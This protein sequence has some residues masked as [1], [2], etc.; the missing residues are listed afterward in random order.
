M[1]Y[2]NSI[3]VLQELDFTALNSTAVK[4]LLAYLWIWLSSLKPSKEHRR[5]LYHCKA[6][7]SSS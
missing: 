5:E 1:W 7:S 6:L 3:N 4:N 2:L